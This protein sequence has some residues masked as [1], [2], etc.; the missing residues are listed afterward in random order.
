MSIHDVPGA[1]ARTRHVAVFS[2][3]PSG[4]AKLRDLLPVEDAAGGRSNEPRRTRIFDLHPTL[5]CSLIGTCLTM[6]EVRHLL[7]KLEVAGART[8]SDHEIHGQGVLLAAQRDGGGKLLNKTLDK[9]HRAHIARFAK[10]RTANEVLALW[11]QHVQDG[12]IPGAYW[13]AITH[14]AAGR[15]RA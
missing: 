5:H 7:V 8:A 10:T 14:P 1:G 3:R 13:A 15:H 11:A 2:S 9:K 4:R 12:D 6:G